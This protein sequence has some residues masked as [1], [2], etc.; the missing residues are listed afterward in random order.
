[1]EGTPLISIII[2]NK[3]ERESLKKCIDSI[4]KKSTYE[5]YE[6]LIVENNSTSKEIFEYYKESVSYTH[7]VQADIPQFS[8]LYRTWKN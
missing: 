4:E 6:I 7:L 5:N 1:M 2:P 3:D 8:V